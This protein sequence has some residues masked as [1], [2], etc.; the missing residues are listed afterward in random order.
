MTN[1]I[2]VDQEIFERTAMELWEWIIERKEK[3]D[4]FMT[5]N[6]LLSTAVFIGLEH[7]PDHKAGL[8]EMQKILNKSVKG[9]HNAAK[10]NDD[11]SP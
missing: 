2:N 3:I 10:I 4:P 7:A 8:D 5:V 11:E 1:E 6:V 9:Y